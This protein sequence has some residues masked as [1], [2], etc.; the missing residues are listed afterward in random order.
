M[1]YC[2]VFAIGGQGGVP[3]LES[4][5]MGILALLNR[6]FGTSQR[7]TRKTIDEYKHELLVNQTREQF[8]Y[9]LKKNL[10]IPVV[11]L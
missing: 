5:C 8:R 4:H 7:V 2:D 10:R 9:L 6:L 1:I 3:V 11:L